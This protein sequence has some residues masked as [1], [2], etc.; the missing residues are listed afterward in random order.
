M[1]L[2]EIVCCVYH[3]DLIGI[4]PETDGSQEASTYHSLQFLC[5][6]DDGRIIS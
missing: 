5:V 4:T 6:L 2:E 3:W 1:P